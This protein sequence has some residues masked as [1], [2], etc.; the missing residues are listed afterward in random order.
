MN[1][2]FSPKEIMAIVSISYKQLEYWDKTE[3]VSPT[4]ETTLKKSRV[5]NLEDLL[6]IYVI[7][8]LRENHKKLFSVQSL[9]AKIAELRE[10]LSTLEDDIYKSVIVFYKKDLFIAVG[11]LVLTETVKDKMITI[12]VKDLM[13]KVIEHKQ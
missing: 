2:F 1:Y 12:P 11:D 6:L 8:Y 10:L 7:K 4:T 5:Y 13:Q 9:R 3:L